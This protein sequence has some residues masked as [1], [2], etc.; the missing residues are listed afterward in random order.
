MAGLCRC[1]QRFTHEEWTYSNNLKY[2]SAEKEREISQG[3]QSECD[4]FM[5]ESAKRTERTS[6]DV[7]KKIG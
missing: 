4:R 7:D 6:K 3:L 5:D 2:R 1:P